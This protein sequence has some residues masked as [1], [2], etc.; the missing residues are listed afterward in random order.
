MKYDSICAEAFRKRLIAA[1]DGTPEDELSSIPAFV[2]KRGGGGS[3]GAPKTGK[4]IE[5]EA[6]ARMAA[7]F[8]TGGLGKGMGTVSGSSGGSSSS[9]VSGMQTPLWPLLVVFISIVVACFA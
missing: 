7:K 9:T 4:E 6:R 8:G 5:A 1:R 3:S 2:P